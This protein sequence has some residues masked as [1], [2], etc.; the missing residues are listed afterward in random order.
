MKIQ[1]FFQK[2]ENLAK[3]FTER[4]AIRKIENN[5]LETYNRH[6]GEAIHP[7]TWPE[8]WHKESIQRAKASFD[9]QGL[10]YPEGD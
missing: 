6:F 1:E 2:A 10:E 5:I 4:T 9:A 3:D 8:Q 7:D